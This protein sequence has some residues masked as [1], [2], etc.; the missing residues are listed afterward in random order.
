MVHRKISLISLLFATEYSF[1]G[2][3][4]DPK[5]ASDAIR[6]FWDRFQIRADDTFTPL[7]S[8][9]RKGRTTTSRFLFDEEHDDEHIRAA[10]GFA[11]LRGQLETLKCL[12][13]RVAARTP[14]PNHLVQPA[15]IYANCFP[16]YGP[17]DKTDRMPI[18]MWILQHLDD[19]LQFLLDL[20]DNCT[21]EG[22]DI[23]AALKFAEVFLC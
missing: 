22:A 11:A 4:P 20:D 12:L 16:D 6:W 8:A 18:A 23:S 2:P 9:I 5:I 10:L 17:S 19:P 14:P 21:V 15:D 1:D 7:M 3:R 13:Y